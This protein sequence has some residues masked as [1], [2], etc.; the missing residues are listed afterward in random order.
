MFQR[1]YRNAIVNI[2]RVGK[3]TALRSHRWMLTLSHSTNHFTR[4]LRGIR[5]GPPGQGVGDFQ[6]LP[7][8]ILGAFH[9]SA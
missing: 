8:A 1:I 7:Q 6:G 4:H 5:G 3:M 9:S 2:G